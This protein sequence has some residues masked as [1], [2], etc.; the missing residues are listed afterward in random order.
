L[1]ASAIPSSGLGLQNWSL[2]NPK[3]IRPIPLQTG[4]TMSIRS[5]LAPVL[6]ALAFSAEASAK[7]DVSKQALER[8]I[9]S[10]KGGVFLKVTPQQYNKLIDRH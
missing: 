8:A 7:K 10:G 3:F 6:T 5:I 2:N 4:A 9:D 1:N